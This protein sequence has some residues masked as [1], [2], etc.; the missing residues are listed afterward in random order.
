MNVRPVTFVHLVELINAANACVGKYQSTALKNKFARHLITV[1]RSCKTDTR[2][3]LSSSVNA[4]GSKRTDVFEQLRFS[5]TGISH[6]EHV[7]VASNLHAVGH[8]FSVATDHKQ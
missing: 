3:T 8:L 1:H 7:N 6:Q 5:N 2:G 4:S